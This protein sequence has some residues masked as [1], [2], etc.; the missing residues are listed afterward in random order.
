MHDTQYT[1]N[2]LGELKTLGVRLAIDDFGTSYSSLAY[3]SAMPVNRL[4]IDKRFIDD[5][6][7]NN[8]AKTVI[9]AIVGLGHGL[10]LEV[11]GEGVEQDVQQRLLKEARCDIAQGYYFA[12]P[13]ALD[14]LMS[15]VATRKLRGDNNVLPFPPKSTPGYVPV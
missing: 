5:L 1:T 14:E 15:F 4:K 12:E 13:M 7:L 10:G 8:S 3:L 9:D 11:V 2:V 6:S